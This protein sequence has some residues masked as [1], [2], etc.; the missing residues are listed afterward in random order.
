MLPTLPRHHSPRK[1]FVA[2]SLRVICHLP[3]ATR[4]SP[5]QTL[6]TTQQLSNCRFRVGEGRFCIFLTQHRLG[7]GAADD[8]FDILTNLIVETT[9]DRVRLD[10]ARLSL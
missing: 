2:C 1:R 7:K 10:T 6:L 9:L 4:H 8:I 5:I 3:L